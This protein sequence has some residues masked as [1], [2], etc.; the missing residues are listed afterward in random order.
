MKKIAFIFGA[1]SIGSRPLNFFANNIN[2]STR[3]LTGSELG[4]LETCKNFIKFGWDVS[5]F[6]VHTPGTKPPQ[7]EG[8]KLFDFDER[9]AIIDDSFDVVVS[10]SECDVFRGL[11]DKPLRVVCQMLNDWT[12]TIPGFDN[13]VDQYTAPCQMLI[14]HLTK[15]A[16]AP[17][18]EKFKVVP[19]GANPEL[20]TEGQRIKGRCVW[21]SSADR[22]LFWV[23]QEWTKIKAAVPY[24]SLRI[25]YNFNYG[26]LDQIE[27]HVTNIIHHTVEMAHR[28]RYMKE[29]IKRLRHL[30]VE[31]I[32]SISREQMI[33]ELN[34]AQLLC[35][36][37]DCVSL[38][39][40]WSVS[41]NEACSAGVLPIITD[42][43]CL[44]AIYGNS[45]PMI[46]SPVKDNINQWTELVIKGLLDDQ[47][48][49]EKLKASKAFGEKYTWLNSAK[50]LEQIILDHPKYQTRRI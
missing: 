11:P 13:F 31:Q 48:R 39:E 37:C 44:G 26:T 7:W 50:L 9:F 28:I 49:Q 32:G 18:V 43:D 46:K 23:F 29:G 5:L 14:E 41:I 38:S 25:F 4:I 10:W 34:Q 12:Y 47:W 8:I 22:G 33:T 19:L 45:V 35:Y 16:N 6:T 36:P 2:V 30:D 3:G 24:A 21:T 27:P 20:Y 1:W 17:L 42:T 15:Q 40:G